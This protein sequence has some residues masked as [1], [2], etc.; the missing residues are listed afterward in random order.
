MSS[1]LL[2]LDI[3]ALTQSLAA[4]EVPQRLYSQNLNVN[5]EQFQVSVDA[6]QQ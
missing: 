2:L 6:A 1:L 3:L 4:M 5:E